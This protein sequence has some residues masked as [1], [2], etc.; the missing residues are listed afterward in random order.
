MIPGGFNLENKVALVAGNGRGWLGEIGSY[1]A[2]AGALVAI[3]DDNQKQLK[4]AVKT[5]QASGQQ[6]IPFP[7]S[8]TDSPDIE[9]TVARIISQCGKIDILVN[10]IDL[11]F[12]GPLLET[13]D[14]DWDRV[15]TRNMTSV[16]LWTRAVGRHMVA[17]KQ[18]SIINVSSIL[19]ERGVANSTAYC[20]SSGG[21]GQFT[22]ALALEWA[23]QNVRVNAIGVG[24]VARAGGKKDE[25]EARLE[26][27]IT[28]GRFCRPDDIATLLVYLASPASSYLTGQTYFASGGAMAH[29]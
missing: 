17:R 7:T 3:A 8:L 27:Y 29:G 10:N 12:A 19:S 5:I 9:K 23:Q 1:L 28:L 25:T 21:I 2:E 11:Q 22:R 4:Q 26:R 16:F 6:V 20:A 13:T 18:G 14:E 24:W 15:I